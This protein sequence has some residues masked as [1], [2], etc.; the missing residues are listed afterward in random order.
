V[1]NDWKSTH[2]DILS[3]RKRKEKQFTVD[4]TSLAF[5]HHI[6][7]KLRDLRDELLPRFKRVEGF[8]Q[9]SFSNFKLIVHVR[10]ASVKP[11][12]SLLLTRE[13]RELIDFKI[14]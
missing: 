8:L 14:L 9:C 6:L 13:Q 11:H 10:D 7:D 3:R 4:P 1:A 5:A 2:Y 12:V